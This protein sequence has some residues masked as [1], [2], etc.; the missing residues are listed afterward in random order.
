MAEA[1]GANVATVVDTHSEP[2]SECDWQAQIGV[3]ATMSSLSLILSRLRLAQT[4]FWGDV[5]DRASGLM[6][7]VRHMENVISEQQ[8]ACEVYTKHVQTLLSQ[9][10]KADLCGEAKAEH[11]CESL[12][13]R[14][15]N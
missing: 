14:G 2:H 8:D 12:G 5:V 4:D 11:E 1:F 6:R 9:D 15:G 3:M 7:T 13:R 10:I